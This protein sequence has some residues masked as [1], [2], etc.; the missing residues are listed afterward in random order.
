MS[1]GDD[2]KPMTALSDEDVRR[3]TDHI[4][5]STGMVF[6]ESKRYY[7]ERRIADRV[8][9]TG[10]PDARTYI[11]LLSTDPTESSLSMRTRTIGPRRRNERRGW[12]RSLVT[13]RSSGTSGARHDAA[14][15]RP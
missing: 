8:A 14:T 5:R 12:P 3:V 10:A 2:A 11:A 7:I 15:N 13:P 4:Y 9:K 6:G 1:D